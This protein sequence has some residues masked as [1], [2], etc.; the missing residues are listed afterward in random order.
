MSDP[1]QGRFERERA[2]RREAEALLHAKSRELYE[3]NVSL[4]ARAAELATSLETLRRTQSQLVQQEKMASLGGL[5][6]GVAHE[7]NTPLGVAVT[8]VTHTADRVRALEAEIS[9]GT[10][11]RGGM[12]GYVED[13][14]EAVSLAL[15]NLERAARLV[16]SFKKVAV[17][18]SSEAPR[19]GVLGE[20][21]ADVIASLRPLTRRAGVEVTVSGDDR[22]R[23]QLD[24]G[25]LVQVITNLLQNACIHA[26]DE[27]DPNRSIRVT[28]STGH[29][30]AEIVVA[31]NGRGMPADV[32]RQVFEPFYTTRRANGG[33][34]LG[35][36]ITHN[37]VTRRFLGTIA[38]DT[39][40]GAG[41]AW[42]L[43]LPFGTAA[44]TRHEDSRHVHAT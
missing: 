6:A 38:L 43:T 44:L 33:S 12:R 5:V 2:A 26:F 23:V 27:G 16:D 3:S 14:N 39:A 24:A 37:L 31:D 25:A 4:E 40:P 35:M 19:E 30:V 29:D 15:A 18:Q 1:W 20:V 7:I 34:G 8:A 21:V 11:T 17:D 28:V 10:L 41:C 36:H 13:L 42:T 32:A 9:A 22:T